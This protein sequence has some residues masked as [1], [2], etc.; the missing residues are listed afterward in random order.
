MWSDTECSGAHSHCIVEN[1]K[2]GETCCGCVY[3]KATIHIRIDF[4]ITEKCYVII[5][6]FPVFFNFHVVSDISHTKYSTHLNSTYTSAMR[7][8]PLW[9][10]AFCSLLSKSMYKKPLTILHISSEYVLI[11]HLHQFHIRWAAFNSQNCRFCSVFGSLSWI[12]INYTIF[13]YLL[14]YRASN[15][16]RKFVKCFLAVF[17]MF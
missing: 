12:Y 16:C 2:K 1:W 15:L 13:L 3:C 4:S 9:S 6:P 17:L 11:S 7:Y 5:I 8:L 10:L 14:K